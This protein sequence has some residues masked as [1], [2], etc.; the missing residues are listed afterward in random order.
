MS[1]QYLDVPFREKDQAKSLGARFDW[2]SKRWY[3]LEGMDPEQFARWLP[4]M[5]A[6]D[7]LLPA[8]VGRPSLPTAAD[9]HTDAALARP[10]HTSTGSAMDTL[11]GIPLSQLLQGISSLVAQ[12]YAQGVWIIVE[13]TEARAQ[14]HVYL[15]VSER[16]ADGRQLAKARAMIWESVASR[17]LPAFEQA[18][19]AVLGAG[20]KLL[21]HA[22][23]VFHVQYGLS[24]QIDAIDADYTLGQL[25]AHRR[26]IRTRLKREGVFEQNRQLPTPWDYR[27]V[28]VLA[29]AQAAGLGDFHREAERLQRHGVCRFVYAYSRFQGEGAA[30]DIVA[31]L[32]AALAD[33][34][35]D[36]LPDAVA[37][38]RGGGAVS[39]LAWLDDY[40][41]SR[42]ICDLG[43]PV[44]TG[45]GHERDNTLPDEVAHLRFDTPSKV[46]TGI[47]QRIVQRVREAAAL[48]QTVFGYAQSSTHHCATAVDLMQ[49]RIRDQ[50]RLHVASAARRV[51]Q[52]MQGVQHQAQQHIKH[53]QG[54]AER[55]F[56]A[57]LSQSQS[58]RQIASQAILTQVQR[59]FERA[60]VSVRSAQT[61]SQSLLREI[62]GQGPDKTLSRGFVIVRASDQRPISSLSQAQGQAQLQIQFKDGQLP[63]KPS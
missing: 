57:V 31:A 22:R 40:D 44:L 13:I 34:P 43:I 60:Q 63:V 53:A 11:R 5:Q 41:L 36:A 20:M 28:L 47:E 42:T 61:E 49:T 6:Q 3:I 62:I 1:K 55:S 7:S 23:P 8:S 25:E 52:L 21:V 56:L 51:P 39:D 4:P 24:L 19:G 9:E 2:E 15:E 33:F 54:H 18:T 46:I 35:P 48:V 26:E 30:R 27:C 38:I 10:A 58:T 37:I 16:D 50:A 14:G 17:I 45:I 59:I 29:P 12:A 32:H